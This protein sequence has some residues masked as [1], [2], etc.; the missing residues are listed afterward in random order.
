MDICMCTPTSF[1]SLLFLLLPL[2][3][4]LLELAVV[5]LILD[6]IVIVVVLVVVVVF[7]VVAQGRCENNNL[8]RVHVDGDMLRS[9]YQRGKHYSFLYRQ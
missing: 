1:F 9:Y 7:V 5:V 4:L 3:L 6:I 8:S 2:L